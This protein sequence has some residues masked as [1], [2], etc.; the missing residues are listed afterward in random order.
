MH[1]LNEL[2]RVLLSAWSNTAPAGCELKLLYSRWTLPAL[3][4]EDYDLHHLIV[5]VSAKNIPE[6]F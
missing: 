4:D 6:T 2:T 3:I 1:L 5:D